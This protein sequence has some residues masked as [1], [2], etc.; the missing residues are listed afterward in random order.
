MVK[1]LYKI[2]SDTYKK[3]QKYFNNYL[4]YAKK[5]KQ[6]SQRLLPDVKVLV[7]GSV[8]RRKYNIDSDID[9]MIIS[10]YIPENIM[11]QTKLGLSVLGDLGS[12]PFQLHLIT[13]KTYKSWYRN[14]IKQNYI[15][16]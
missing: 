1:S 15:E 2:L 14:F 11:E 16:V 3:Q 8:V 10:D 12:H 6:N 7:F 13:Y 5:I 4:W 9:I